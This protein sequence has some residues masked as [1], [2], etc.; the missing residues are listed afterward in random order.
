[1][2]AVVGLEVDGTAHSDHFSRA[3]AGRSRTN[4]AQHDRVRGGAA[5][6]PQLHTVGFVLGH[7]DEVPI[8]VHQQVWVRSFLSA[9]DVF[10][11]VGSDTDPSRAQSSPP[12]SLSHA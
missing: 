9:E 1:M 5:T 11:P 3:A 10:D 2:N 8:E 7:E 4:V 6:S 12:W